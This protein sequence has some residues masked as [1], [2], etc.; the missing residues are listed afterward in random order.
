MILFHYVVVILAL[1]VD[2]SDEVEHLLLSA[3]P[4]LL[5]TLGHGIT[6]RPQSLAEEAFG[7]RGIPLG[8]EEKVNRLTGRIHRSV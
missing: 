4:P 7:R 3:L 2:E 8:R 5:D 1:A 6:G